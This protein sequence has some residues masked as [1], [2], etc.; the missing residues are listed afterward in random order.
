MGV[1]GDRKAKITDAFCK[2]A[3]VKD[4]QRVTVYSDA[5]HKNAL[6]GFCLIVTEAGSKSLAVRYTLKRGDEAGTKKRMVLGPYPG[7][8]V[9]VYR[10][11]A[12]RV[13]ADAAQGIDASAAEKTNRASAS[14]AD[15]CERYMRVHASQKRSGDVDRRRL[16]KYV[17]PEWKNRKAKSITRAEVSALVD[18]IAHGDRDTEGR[19]YEANRV[20]AL[21]KT[22]F[23]FG[24]DKGL[25]DAHPCAGLKGPGKEE[26]KTRHLCAPDDLRAFWRLT[27][28]EF[29]EHMPPP[30]AAALRFQLLS[31]CRPGE[32][33]GM[34]WDEVDMR[35]GEWLL[36]AKRSKNGRAH[37][38][39]LTATLRE[40]LK[41]QPRERSMVFP[42]ERGGRTTDRM[43]A[44]ILDRTLDAMN[45]AIAAEKGKPLQRF[46]PHDLRRTA[47][48]AMA[49]ARVPKEYRDRLL[50]HVDASVGGTHYNHHDYKDEK[51]TALEALDAWVTA[52]LRDEDPAGKVIKFPAK[53]G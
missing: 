53:A 18:S 15:L 39:P 45:A 41:E 33:F 16:D 51:R 50:N 8:S 30:F 12:L 23:S 27:S 6:P 29:A 7:Q 32:V 14:V 26:P 42:A 3:T 2:S 36:P 28:G 37:L 13:R 20:L 4:G 31:A 25:V 40:I 1:R 49:A 19:P 10:E 48:T 24:I 44:R 5:D 9:A 17:L 46:T 43:R 47:E 22:L 52:T 34:P 21:I 38:V 35:H 11:Q